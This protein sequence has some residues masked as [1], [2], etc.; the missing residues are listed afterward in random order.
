MLKSVYMKLIY[1]HCYLEGLLAATPR[2]C[3]AELKINKSDRTFPLLPVPADTS[4][5]PSEYCKIECWKLYL[6]NTKKL[7]IEWDDLTEGMTIRHWPPRTNSLAKRGF[8]TCHAPYSIFVQDIILH[9]RR[10]PCLHQRVP[11]D[12]HRYSDFDRFFLER[13]LSI[14]NG[15]SSTKSQHQIGEIDTSIALGAVLLP[16]PLIF[17]STSG[18]DQVIPNSLRLNNFISLSNE[19]RASSIIQLHTGKEK[20]LAVF[21]I[22]I[23]EAISAK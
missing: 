20:H 22:M 8:S 16:T 13:M 5:M 19:R 11:G 9:H 3:A 15:C 14:L 2:L 17:V 7:G 12:F 18:H 21:C 10:H 1:Q 6:Y 23:V 4:N